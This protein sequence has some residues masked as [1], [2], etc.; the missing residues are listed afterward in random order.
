M[1]D[2]SIEGEFP[3]SM[4][5]PG[6]EGEFPVSMKDPGIEGEF[7]VSMKDPGI[8]GEFPVSMKDPGI[9]EKSRPSREVL[10]SILASISSLTELQRHLVLLEI[11]AHN[12]MLEARLRVRQMFVHQGGEIVGTQNEADRT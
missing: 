5:D 2:R 12:S 7:P 10:A 9:C 8:E 11:H 3:I 1:R 6:I 4:K